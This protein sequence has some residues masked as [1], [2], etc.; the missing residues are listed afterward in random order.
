[1][2]SISGCNQALAAVK[3]WARPNLGCVQTLAAVKPWLRPYRGFGKVQAVL[4]T[5]IGG[6][7]CLYDFELLFLFLSYSIGSYVIYILYTVQC[8]LPNTK[9]D[10]PLCLSR[11]PE[12]SSRKVSDVVDSRH[13]VSYVAYISVSISVSN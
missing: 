6:H 3:P 2:G 9:A 1:M 8:L 7:G 11:I 4:Y 12:E 5:L 10:E 13:V